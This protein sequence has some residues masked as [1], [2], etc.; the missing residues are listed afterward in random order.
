MTIS[1]IWHTF[2]RCG[3]LEYSSVCVGV[4]ALNV[5]LSERL[6]G[7]WVAVQSLSAE[8]YGFLCGLVITIAVGAS[9]IRHRLAATANEEWLAVPLTLLLIGLAACPPS[10]ASVRVA[11]VLAFLLPQIPLF[12][13]SERP[14]SQNSHEHKP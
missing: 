10:R 12:F 9:R 5:L 3:G 1:G 14:P 13:C 4:V 11:V 8:Q 2:S 6:W 7:S